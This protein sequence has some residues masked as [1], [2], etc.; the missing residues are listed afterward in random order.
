MVWP[1]TGLFGLRWDRLCAGGPFHQTNMFDLN[2][3]E[4][5]NVAVRR[6]YS[7]I[8]IKISYIGGSCNAGY[9]WGCSVKRFIRT[10]TSASIILANISAIK[11]ETILKDMPPGG[12]L[13]PGETVF[14]D[15][16]S[17]PKGQMKKVTG[18]ENRKYVAIIG[19][20]EVRKGKSRIVRCVKH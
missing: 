12:S 3:A 16:G 15:D 14:V 18:G 10:L 13:H 6:I 1:E 8:H 2:I 17:C 11:A 19:S 9:W 7:I 4:M 5:C 20:D